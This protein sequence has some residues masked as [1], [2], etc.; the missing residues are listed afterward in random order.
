[1]LSMAA[2][3]ATLVEGLEYDECLA[4]FIQSID[5]ALLSFI[6]RS[7]KNHMCS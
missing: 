7:M 4:M 1:M 6:E 3:L 2:S 5:M